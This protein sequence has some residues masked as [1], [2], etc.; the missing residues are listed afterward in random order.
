MFS[1]LGL[2]SVVYAA[3]KFDDR[4]DR[5]SFFESLSAGI[6]RNEWIDFL[7]G[8]IQKAPRQQHFGLMSGNFSEADMTRASQLGYALFGKPLAMAQ[9]TTWIEE[10]ERTIPPGRKLFDWNYIPID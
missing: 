2:L 4:L 10:A 3:L 5:C 8:L 6:R 9:L 1:F 7:E